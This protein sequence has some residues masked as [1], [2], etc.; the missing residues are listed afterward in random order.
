MLLPALRLLN[1]PVRADFSNEQLT[2]ALT[3]FLMRQDEQM[4]KAVRRALAHLLELLES[5]AEKSKR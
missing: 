2:E 3:K 1:A 5:R 4:Q